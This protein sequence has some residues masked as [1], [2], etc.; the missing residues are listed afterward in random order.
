VPPLG[1]TATVQV[2]PTV[3]ELAILGIVPDTAGQAGFTVMVPLAGADVSP[4][5][6]ETVHAIVLALNEAVPAFNVMVAVPCPD[7]YVT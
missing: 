7:T 3:L 4:Q 6:F 2:S 1:V 5:S